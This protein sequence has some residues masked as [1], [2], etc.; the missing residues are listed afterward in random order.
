MATTTFNAVHEQH[1]TQPFFKALVARF[2]HALERQR[3]IQELEGLDD[4]M[5]ADIGVSRHDIPR[6]VDGTRS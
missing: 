1:T 2:H 4:R 6:V 5:L 3:A